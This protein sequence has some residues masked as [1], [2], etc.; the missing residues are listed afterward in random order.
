MILVDEVEGA[1][2]AYAAGEPDPSAVSLN[3]RFGNIEA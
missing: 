2:Y 1:A 3:N